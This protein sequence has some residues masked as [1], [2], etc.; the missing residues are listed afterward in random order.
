[1]ARRAGEFEIEQF[2][3]VREIDFIPLYELPEAESDTMDVM[4]VSEMDETDAEQL[5]ESDEDVCTTLPLHQL[6]LPDYWVPDTTFT[7][8]IEDGVTVWLVPEQ[9]APCLIECGFAVYHYGQALVSCKFAC[10]LHSD[11]DGEL[12][13]LDDDSKSWVLMCRRAF[14]ND[15]HSVFG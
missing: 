2:G 15:V 11:Y 14:T 9:V 3:G 6:D 12:P 13:P 10:W 5:D 8:P 7:I 1:M 4:D